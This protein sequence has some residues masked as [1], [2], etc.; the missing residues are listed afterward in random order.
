MSEIQVWFLVIAILLM[1][2][3]ILSVKCAYE[4]G[5]QDGKMKERA[6]WRKWRKEHF[7]GR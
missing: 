4:L 7:N 3:F 5:F 6:Y 1:V 2:A